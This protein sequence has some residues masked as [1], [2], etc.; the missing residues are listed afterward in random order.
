MEE[1]PTF[2]ICR[3][4]FLTLGIKAF[5]LSQYGQCFQSLSGEAGALNLGQRWGDPSPTATLDV[6][7]RTVTSAASFFDFRTF[8]PEGVIFYGDTN[9]G[10]DWFIL[11]LRKGKPEMQIHNTV[12]NL[13]VSGGLRLNDGRWHRL[14]VK[15]EGHIVLLEVDG[16][17]QLVLSHVSHPIIDQTSSAMRIGVGGLFIPAQELLMPVSPSQKLQLADPLPE[18]GHGWV[19]EALGLAEQEFGVARGKLLG[20]RGDQGLP[21]RLGPASGNWSLAVEMRIE[22]APQAATLLAIS[23][24]KHTPVL[25]LDLRHTDLVAQLGNKTVFMVPLPAEGCLDLQLFMQITPSHLALRMANSETLKP[26]PKT[27]FESLKQIWLGQR[28][29]LII[30]GLPGSERTPLAQERGFFRGCLREIRV[31]GWELDLDAAQSRSNSIWAHSCPGLEDGG[32]ANT[33]GGN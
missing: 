1:D 2:V 21:T 22:G 27:D 31:Q 25:R 12:T 9:N 5:S 19:H 13:T 26:I 32:K 14:M 7:L 10:K 3:K 23:G 15:N 17:D 8:D 28:G 6:D 29:D 16:D 24:V 11:A 18:H 33:D 30:G 4:A 20:G